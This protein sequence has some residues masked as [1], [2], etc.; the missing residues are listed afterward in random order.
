M[1][2]WVGWV[3]GWLLCAVPAAAEQQ[4]Q[5]ATPPASPPPSSVTVV[6]PTQPY[7]S[8]I[9]RKSYSLADDLQK[10]TGAIADVLRDVPAVQVDL[11]GNVSLRGE[12]DVTILVD[13]KP[14]A[15]FSGPGRA[16]ALQSIPADQYER[17][18][19]MTNPPAGVTAEGSGGVINLIS[20]AP[21]KG[22][23]AP[24]ASGTF[25]AD[26]G[27][28]D[29]FD[30][31]ASAAFS[32]PG[33]SITGGANLQRQ[34]SQW[35]TDAH[36]AI[37]DPAGGAPVPATSR[38]RD[39]LRGQTITAFGKAA[40]DPDPSD[41]LDAS[42]DLV[43]D[44]AQQS[45]DSAY[46][47]VALDYAAPGFW[48]GHYTALSGSAGE[49]R[50]LPGDDH[51]LSIK[52]SLSQDHTIVQNGATY[53]YEAPVQPDLYQ[54]ITQLQS[55]R[56]IDLTV[57]YKAPLRHKAKLSL[58]YEGKFDWQ[59][60]DDHG[61]QGAVLASALAD[62][63][64]AQGFSFD[65]Q[66]QAL[67]A[68]YEQALGKL[69]VQPGIRLE[70]VTLQTDLVSPVER[71][72][73]AYLDAYPSLHLDYDLDNGAALKASYSR[74]VQRPGVGSLDPFRIEFSQTSYFAGN[75]DLK[76]A[77][78]QSW[79]LGYEYRKQTT[80]LQAT[81]FYRDKS[82]VFTT[83]SEE[84]GGDVLLS[85]LENLG[86][87]HDVGL[88]FVA[89]RELIKGLTLNASTDL[90]RSEVDAANLGILGARSAYIASGRATLNWQASPKDFIQLGGQAS[91]GH[92]TA[93][94]YES[95]SLQSD[96]GW[97]HRF[98]LR[99]AAL[100]TVHDPFGLSRHSFVID[101]PGFSETYSSKLN[102]AAVFL[103]LTYALGAPP[104]AAADN[105]DF[106]S[107]GQPAR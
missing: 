19:V 18:E 80:D 84:L 94:G 35:Q 3:I 57:D 96:L 83:V 90:M 76:P 59:H 103:G 106:G 48:H 70:S 11:D 5:P 46:D 44:R 25:K 42:L 31:N 55:S 16:Q 17:V 98:D 101:T 65:Q 73:Q 58:G 33:V 27:S 95:G 53:E 93:Q 29:R 51:S 50:S 41:H 56:Q 78:T 45:Q 67:Y 9:D 74:R 52:L 4:A 75:A 91:G 26:V 49:T 62:P 37:P 34:A 43:S 85:T 24:S 23:T 87:Q 64:F 28:G 60:Q 63:V 92:L 99:L 36:Y 72:R 1:A 10:S 69:T 105:F 61:V 8:A 40:Y 39:G 82:D 15:L 88:E 79:E 2:R 30:V 107:S 81:V 97:R 68:T 21:P 32:A 66:V 100:F 54:D 77:I 20:K 102:R 12:S 7:K 38:E 47:S 104:K 86:H 13:G 89:N 14:S 6:A 22:R 71:G